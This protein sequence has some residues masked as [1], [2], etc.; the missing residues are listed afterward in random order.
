MA[1]KRRSLLVLLEILAVE[2]L[3]AGLVIAGILVMGFAANLIGSE[4]VVAQ[5]RNDWQQSFPL[6][7]ASLASTGESKYFVLKPGYRL[8]L[9]SGGR[10]PE[11]LLITVL[12]Q[13]RTIDG[14]ETRVVEERET[15]GSE[16]VEV[17]RNFFAI[18][19]TTGDV[20][21]FGEEVDIYKGGAVVGHEGAWQHGTNGA[22]FGLMVPGA[23]VVGQRYYQEQAKGV[24]MDRAEVVSVSAR[25]RTRDG[26]FEQ[27]LELKET[28]PLEVGTETKL[29]AP[30]LGLLEDGDMTLISHGYGAPASK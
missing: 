9:S 22:R 30:G 12:D 13:T 29:Y 21:Y 23:P 6:N 11:V 28:T 15:H 24:A 19:R 14:V 10:N 2:I 20:F 16:L 27:C 25:L 5:V 17:S 4:R 8:Q 3:I 26:S 18:N 7:R 1:H